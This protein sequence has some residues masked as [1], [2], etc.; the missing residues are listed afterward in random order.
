VF[1]RLRDARALSSDLQVVLND[2]KPRGG[3]AIT[4]MKVATCGNYVYVVLKV[5]RQ[6]NPQSV[7]ESGV[8]TPE[9]TGQHLITKRQSRHGLR[10]PSQVPTM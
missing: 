10:Y 4:D 9:E 7:V 3:A 1:A 5:L 6:A 2:N 8:C